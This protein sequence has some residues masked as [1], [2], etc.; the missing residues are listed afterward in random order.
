MK[1]AYV[2]LG[3]P[4]NAGTEEIQEAYQRALSHFTKERLAA[5]PVLLTRREEVK[6]AF[7]VLSNSDL[8]QAHDRKI[9][10]YAAPR[11][12]RIVEVNKSSS[13]PAGTLLKYLALGV[14]VIFL[15]GT[16]VSHQRA[17]AKR[18]QEAMEL[19]QKKE[20]EQKA[21]QAEKQ[22][23]AVADK[24]AAEAAQIARNEQRLRYESSQIGQRVQAMDIMQQNMKIMREN[25]EKMAAA[26]NDKQ[27]AAYAAA[28]RAAADQNALRNLCILN[29]GRPNC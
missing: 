14:V 26:N 19:A 6:E 23:A 5:D 15:G 22:A 27:Q 9:N 24:K 8:R 29:T 11:P 18:E 2:T 3:I 28:R 7:K 17:E 21:E 1:S 4:G 13:S 20:E 12:M 16:Y 25:Q 10:G